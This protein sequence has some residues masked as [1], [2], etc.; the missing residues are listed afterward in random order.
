MMARRDP[1][2]SAHQSRRPPSPPPLRRGPRPFPLRFAPSISVSVAPAR[3][4]T[5]LLAIMPPHSGGSS[6][7]VCPA[8]LESHGR[9]QRCRKSADWLLLQRRRMPRGPT[10]RSE[11]MPEPQVPANPLPHPASY[12]CPPISQLYSPCELSTF[13]LEAASPRPHANPQRSALSS[14]PLV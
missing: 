1:R 6:L 4:G 14:L 13:H 8:P 11:R 7:H 3:N 9:C 12:P 2:T 10:L 5:P